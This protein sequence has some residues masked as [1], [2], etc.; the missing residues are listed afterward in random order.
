VELGDTHIYSGTSGWVSTVVGKSMVDT[1]AMIAAIVGAQEGSFNYFAEQETAGKCVEWVKDH[2]ALDEINLYLS[3]EFDLK[4]PTPDME[5]VYTNLYDYLMAVIS[6]APIGAGGVIF[7]PWLHGNRCPFEDPKARG[8]FFNISLETGKT[9]MIRAVVEGVIYHL[10]WMLETQDKKITTSNPVRFVGGGALSD[11]MCQMMADCT[12]RTV[13]TVA[14]PQNVGS[15]GAAVLIA[16]G[17]HCIENV[18]QA[19]RLIPAVKTFP[20]NAANKAAYDKNYEVFKQLYKA[21]K[22]LFAQMG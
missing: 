12:G 8:M 9:E 18:A 3:R 13:E 7:T 5:T 17:Q 6:T 19:K 10:R 1:T 15:V 11:I 20:P 14:S 21:N 2:L 22:K 16:V 4:H